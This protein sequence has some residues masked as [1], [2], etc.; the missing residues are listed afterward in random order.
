MSDL[1]EKFKSLQ[2]RSALAVP[3][4]ATGQER[5]NVANTRY[6]EAIEKIKE[7]GYDPAT[8]ASVLKAKKEE[9]LEKLE[10]AEAAMDAVEES[11]DSIESVTGGV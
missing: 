1:T 2:K 3:R 4:L 5:L 9:L 11:L 7:A 10:Q 8:V 6:K